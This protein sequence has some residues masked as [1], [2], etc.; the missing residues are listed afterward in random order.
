MPIHRYYRKKRRGPRVKRY[1]RSFYSRE[2]KL[3]KTIGI[4][5]LVVV[6]LVLA[7]LAAPHVLDWA[8]HTW[9][10]VVRDRDLS[11]S[12]AVAES[13]AADSEAEAASE[14]Q[15]ASEPEEAPLPGTTIVGGSWAEVDVTT[16]TDADSI[17]A[18]ARQLAQSGAT[19]AVLTLKDSDGHLYYQTQTAAAAASV[20]DTLVDAGQIASI[21]KEEGLVPVARLH[22]FRDPIATRTVRSMAIHYTGEAYLWLD[23]KAS[24]GGNPWL[25]PYSNEA[26]QFI[27]DLVEEVHDLGFDHI[28]LES[29]QFPTAQNGRQDFGETSGR[30]RAQ[31]L[32]ADITLWQDRFDGTVTLWYGYSLNQCT[33]TSTA[34]GGTAVELG[35]KNLVV[36]IPAS[37]TQDDAGRSALVQTAEDA[38]AEH[39]VIHDDAA[40]VYE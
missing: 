3:K 38:G 20:A 24:A 7:W 13:A 27:G 29:V 11:A 40:G 10:T 12:S 26:V 4:A 17:C 25:N 37:S 8:T 9:Y 34:L 6:V 33:E 15:A 2:M 22:A 30:S 36:T 23:N 21:F 32:A 1:R 28:L 16:L 18:A 5:V 14:P 35:A 39:V 31:Q 19:Y